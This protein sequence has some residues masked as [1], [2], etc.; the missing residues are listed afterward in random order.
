MV[1]NPHDAATLRASLPVERMFGVCLPHG[2]DNSLRC[3]V[4]VVQHPAQTLTAQHLSTSISC[5]PLWQD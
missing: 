2:A 4:V 5:Y 1:V 3:P